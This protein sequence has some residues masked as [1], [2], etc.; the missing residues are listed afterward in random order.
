MSKE[1]IEINKKT[2]PLHYGI[3]QDNYMVGWNDCLDAVLQ[4]KT[5]DVEPARHGEW[6]KIDYTT[7][8]KCSN[9]TCMTDM[10]Y[11]KKLFDYCPKCGARMD[12]G[13]K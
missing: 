1:Y 11:Q 6:I 9:C 13:N 4:H 12:G 5:V 8:Y 7:L 3:A 10:L 2:F